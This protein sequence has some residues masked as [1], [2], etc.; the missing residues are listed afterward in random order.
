M[1]L[2]KTYLLFGEGGSE[3]DPLL[4]KDVNGSDDE[5]WQVLS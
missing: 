5:E 2:K 4:L 3:N 1:R